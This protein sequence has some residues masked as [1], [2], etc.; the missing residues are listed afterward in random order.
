MTSLGLSFLS[1]RERPTPAK[2]ASAAGVPQIFRGSVA[3][4]AE[5]PTLNRPHAGSSPAGVTS[6][7]T[8]IGAVSRLENGWAL[9]PW[10]FDSLPFRWRHGREAEGSALLA[11][12]QAV[13]VRRF[14]SCCLR[15]HSGVVE[16]KDARLLIARRRF[17]PCRRSLF[18]APVVER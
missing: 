16:R 3:Q 15:F 17:D 8:A 9:R 11:R 1:T 6:G 12:R 10:G 2:P 18:H 7:R 5:Q 14:E 13:L 4:K